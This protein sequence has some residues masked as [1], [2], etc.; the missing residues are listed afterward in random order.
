M[1]LLPGSW[2]RR[3][4]RR[5]READEAGAR[6]LEAQAEHARVLRLTAEV[7]QIKRANGFTEAVIEAMGVR[8]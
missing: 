1:R 6:L 7:R 3:V 5:E 4:E 8:R 2:L